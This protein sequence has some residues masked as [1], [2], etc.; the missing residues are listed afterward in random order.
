MRLT[1]EVPQV[2]QAIETGNLNLTTASQVGQFLRNERKAGKSYTP[3][4]KTEI[5]M[6]MVGKSSRECERELF[7]ISPESARQLGPLGERA[8]AVSATETEI[9][10]IASAELMEKLERLRA[11][12]AHHGSLNYAQL[13]ERLADQE[14][15]RIDPLRKVK[16]KTD[17]ATHNPAPVQKTGLDGNIADNGAVSCDPAKCENG[18]GVKNSA[19]ELKTAAAIVIE[20]SA[21]AG[22]GTGAGTGA[23]TGTGTGTGTVLALRL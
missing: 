1:R 19:L 12:L 18:V 15:K 5:T 7:R 22:T 21:G 16:Q 9:K 20:A 3:T 23:G 13:F 6:Q 4:Q 14:L 10:F 11:L 2:A 8:R 17:N